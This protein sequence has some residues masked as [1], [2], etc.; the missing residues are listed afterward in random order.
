MT[1]HD[2]IH[3]LMQKFQDGYTKCDLT[4]VDPFM[5]LFIEDA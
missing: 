4:Q 3:S 2:E 1:P 5:D